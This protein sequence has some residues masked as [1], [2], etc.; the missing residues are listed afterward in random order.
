MLLGSSDSVS[1]LGSLAVLEFSLKLR[2]IVTS[3]YACSLSLRDLSWNRLI[4][5][6]LQL[7]YRHLVI[8]VDGGSSSLASLPPSLPPLPDS[9]GGGS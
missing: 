6:I 1:V 3:S 4:A 9:T 2:S 5:S 7:G 8:M